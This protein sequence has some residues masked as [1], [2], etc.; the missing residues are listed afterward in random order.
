MKFTREKLD[1][2]LSKPI[3]TCR[4]VHECCVCEGEI[5]DGEKYFDGGYEKRAHVKCA[6]DEDNLTAR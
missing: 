6:Q 4:Y 1:R 5:V 2:I 3:R